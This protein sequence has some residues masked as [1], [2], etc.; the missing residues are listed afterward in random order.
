MFDKNLFYEVKYNNEVLWLIVNDDILSEKY[1]LDKNDLSILNSMVIEH[2]SAPY[3]K[4]IVLPESFQATPFEMAIV[5]HEIGHILLGHN[6]LTEDSAQ[7]EREIAADAF[8]S[9]SPL[10]YQM[11]IALLNGFTI[12]EMDGHKDA[13]FLKDMTVARLTALNRRLLKVE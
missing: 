11:L 6:E 2:E 9:S 10:C 5:E 1:E 8:I 3:N 4:L 7:V 12:L 13:K